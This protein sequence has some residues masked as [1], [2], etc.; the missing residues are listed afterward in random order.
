MT[1]APASAPATPSSPWE[2][3]AEQAGAR[4]TEIG[5]QYRAAQAPA[6]A[7]APP[8][9]GV[10]PTSPA[11]ARALLNARAADPQWRNRVLAGSGAEARQFQE[12]SALAA[13]G[14]DGG[15]NVLIETVDSI[16]DP[17]ALSRGAR[18]ALYDGL[19]E[20]GMNAYQESLFREIDGGR[21]VYVSEGD[22]IAARRVLDRL[23]RN[24]EL[25]ALRMSGASTPYDSDII[26]L[27]WAIG[28]DS[29]DGRPVTEK[30]REQLS[31]RGWL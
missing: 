12:W 15:P 7:V 6:D 29:K 4:L 5:A 22:A 30:A 2:M 18:E 27:Q 14:D 20:R 21:P 23:M 19:R 24:P 26:A 28:H 1:D 3:N 9:P 17:S 25:R 11:Q 16:S 13:S 10:A 8:P 31:A